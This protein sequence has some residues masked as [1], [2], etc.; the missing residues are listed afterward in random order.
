[1]TSTYNRRDFLIAAA[2]A[3]AAS[4]LCAAPRL[5]GWRLWQLEIKRP[6]GIPEWMASTPS[7]YAY[8]R[9]LY[10]VPN[11]AKLEDLFRVVAA[12]EID[13]P[14]TLTPL[15]DTPLYAEPLDAMSYLEQRHE[16]AVLINEPQSEPPDV[17]WYSAAT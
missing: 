14:Y 16:M 5:R 3:V 13:E 15:L 9:T 2:V 4:P 1:M 8:Y 7:P 6:H 17:A 10:L 11:D 12:Q